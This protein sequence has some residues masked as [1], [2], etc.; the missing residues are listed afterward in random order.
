MDQLIFLFVNFSF[1]EYI[2]IIKILLIEYK[3]MLTFF[4]ISKI[5]ITLIRFRIL[6]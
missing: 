4:P 1:M 6:R 5:F 3:Y 2:V